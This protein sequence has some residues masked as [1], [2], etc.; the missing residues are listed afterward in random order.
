MSAK[1]LELGVP[2]STQIDVTYRCA[3]I[4]WDE[5]AGLHGMR[6]APN[7]RRA[8]GARER[9]PAAKKIS[10]V[11]TNRSEIFKDPKLTIGVD[12]R[13]R[14]SHYCILNEAG[15]VGLEDTLP[16]TPRGIQKTLCGVPRSR[17]AL[18]TGTHQTWVKRRVCLLCA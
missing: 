2:L 18:Q 5:K 8:R 13:D 17:R 16:T 12:L 15:G 14:T 4:R 3:L 10:T 1:A 7:D 6:Y 11:A 9:R